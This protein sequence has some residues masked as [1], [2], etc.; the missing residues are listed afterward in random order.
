MTI[1]QYGCIIHASAMAHIYIYMKY[2]NI[3]AR[4]VFK[5][6]VACYSMIVYYIMS[7]HV[8]IYIYYQYMII[9]N[10]I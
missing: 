5:Y 2:L 4:Y 6:F 9:Y 3:N 10:Y 8:C 1:P 7:H